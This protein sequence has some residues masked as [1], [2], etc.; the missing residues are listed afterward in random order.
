MLLLAPAEGKAV[1]GHILPDVHPFEGSLPNLKA[2]RETVWLALRQAIAH[3][4]GL[5]KIFDLKGANLGG[6]IEDNESLLT[7]PVC[8][9]LDRYRTGV[10]YNAIGFENLPH[11]AQCRFLT[12]TFIFSGL[13]GVLRPDD[14][15]PRYKLKIEAVLPQIGKLAAFW[16]PI[17]GAFLAEVLKDQ[18]VWNLLPAAHEAAWENHETYQRM[19]YVDFVQVKNGVRKT[20]SHGVKPLRGE[21]VRHLLLADLKDP[22]ALAN[23]TFS[24]GFSFD[25]AFSKA[26]FAQQKM[27]LVFCK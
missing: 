18:V 8:P 7:A 23:Y 4:K 22:M 10:M 20:V 9:A 6:A 3:G 27:R 5:D 16:K 24:A 12:Q 26:D 14:L 19:V 11:E 1:G 21:L 15:I 17:L 2:A 25:E 13:F